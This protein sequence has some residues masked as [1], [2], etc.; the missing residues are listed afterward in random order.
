M[1][2]NAEEREDSGD[3]WDYSEGGLVWQKLRLRVY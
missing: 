1:W 3:L 2:M